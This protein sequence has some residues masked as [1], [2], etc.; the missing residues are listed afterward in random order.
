MRLQ[1]GSKELMPVVYWRSRPVC[2]SR[3]IIYL[4]GHVPKWCGA[5]ERLQGMFSPYLAVSLLAQL[6]IGRRM[7][8]MGENEALQFH[9]NS[10]EA[11]YTTST[12]YTC[13]IIIKSANN[14]VC[15][16]KFHQNKKHCTQKVGYIQTHFVHIRSFYIMLVCVLWI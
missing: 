3:Y 1:S 4:L 5:Q 11:G 16:M 7:S 12:W 8:F 15:L 6:R 13:I 2:T 14:L 10:G 9:K